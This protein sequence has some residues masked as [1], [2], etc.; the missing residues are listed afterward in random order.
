[1]A[2]DKPVLEGKPAADADASESIAA[3]DRFLGTVR[4]TAIEM[5][6]Q[7]PVRGGEDEAK[8]VQNLLRIMR[9]ALDWN[10]ENVDPGLPYLSAWEVA[11]L[12]AGSV[13]G[14]MDSP[15]SFARLDAGRTYRLSGTTDGLMDV[16]VQVRRDFP[17]KD[18]EVFGDYGFAELKPV[19][20]KWEVI[21]GPRAVEG[22]P[23]LE[24]PEGGENLHLFLRLYWVDWN[25]GPRPLVEIECLDPA[26]PTPALTPARLSG[27]LDRAG[28]YLKMRA[29]FT[30]DWYEWFLKT[31]KTPG[32]IPGGNSHVNYF[33]ERYSLAAGEALLLEFD[34]PPARY[35]CTQ[36]YDGII[37]DN[38]DFYRN[39]NCRNHLQS[40]AAPSGRIQMVVAHDDPGVRNWLDTGGQAE[41][42]VQFRS[43]WAHGPSDIRMR[44]V[45]VSELPGLIDKGTPRFSAEQRREELAAYRRKIA[46]HFFW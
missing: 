10:T 14:N 19:D 34:Q 41:G 7:R 36:L 8:I 3:L 1:M 42:I 44:K 17:P 35:W 30:H 28:D 15:Y 9:H 12:T 26:G 6:A 4:Q 16:N 22:K 31:V 23:F 45:R 25:H 2:E 43:I 11:T 5:I 24:L 46:H 38:G 29:L 33:G 27:L 37:Y 39:I 13:G 18:M 40:D 32:P 20:G 21:M